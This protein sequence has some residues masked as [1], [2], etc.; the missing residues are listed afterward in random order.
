MKE[1]REVLVVGS[2]QSLINSNLDWAG[3]L[4]SDLRSLPNH[5]VQSL[6]KSHF[7]GLK[8]SLYFL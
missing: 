4:P 8:L 7:F 5:S 2:G 3:L 6:K 1:L